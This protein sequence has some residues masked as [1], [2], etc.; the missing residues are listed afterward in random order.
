[1]LTSDF[2]YHLPPELIASEPLADRSSS[3]MRVVHRDSGLIEHRMFRDLPNFL[4]PEDML[5]LNNT[6][7]VPARF[8]SN[9]GTREVLRLE[10]ITPTLWRCMVKPG[11][12]FRLGHTVA[13][14]DSTGTVKEILE[15]GER[16]IEWDA[17]VDENLHGHLALPHYMGRD[18]QPM[19]R[20]RYQ[21][22]FAKSEGAIA[23]PTAGLHFTPELL[24]TLPHTFVTLHVGVGTFQPVKAEKIEEHTMHSEAYEVSAETAAKISKAERIV[25]VGTTSLRTL[26]TV[27]RDHGQVVEAAGSTDIFIYP[28]YRFRAVGALLTN[29]HLPKSTL[30]ML[31]SAFA[32]KE[33][34]MS[35]YAEAIRE[36]Y[37]FFSYG[38]CML[39]L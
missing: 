7:V 36:R 24:A 35:A 26:E 12:R 19:D 17:P 30:I 22:V 38:D 31:V 1:V 21:T 27:A 16:I 28:G 4:T 3:R 20:E 5:V 15:N 14:G 6:R 23:A 32:G 10:P 13:I 29:F 34:I 37:R 8:F 2:D 9:D 18:D 11:K 39:I 33:L 25:A